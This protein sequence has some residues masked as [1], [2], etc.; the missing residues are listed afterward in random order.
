MI[1]HGEVSTKR[2]AIDFPRDRG[3]MVP[4]A[5][6]G[7]CSCASWA[8]V[9]VAKDG[10]ERRS[11]G[12]AAV[13]HAVLPD[14]SLFLEL[15]LD[16]RRKEAAEQ[17]KITSSGEVLLVDL[18]ETQGRVAIP[19]S[20]TYG[21]DAPVELSPFAH[22]DFGALPLSRRYSVSLELRARGKPDARFGPVHVDD[23]RVHASLRQ[24]GAVTVLDVRVVPDRGLGL[25]AMRTLIS[26]ET[27]LEGGYVVPIPVTGQVVDDIEVRPMERISFGRIDLGSEQTGE[28]IL[29]DHDTSRPAEF[30][31]LGIRGVVGKDLA[32]HFDAV[33]QTIDGD[34]RSA[35]LVL[36]YKGTY[37]AT[38]AFRGFVD[39]GKRGQP[40]SVVSIEFVGF[41][42]E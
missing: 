30:V 24:D 10:S 21:I 13:E 14:E 28:V 38:R 35:R 33:L 12:R 19:V 7:N 23:P 41:G 39:L 20:F 34:E 6:R 4:L 8:F 36:R 27:D 22:V 5:F 29:R 11:L 37:S 18:G 16:T 1:P 25:G 31:V 42:N 40:G 26:V 9:A 3:P 17:A 15:S 2:V 32:N